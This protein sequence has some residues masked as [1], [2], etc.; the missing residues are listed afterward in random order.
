MDVESSLLSAPT[1]HAVSASEVMRGFGIDPKRGL[2]DDEVRR[3]ETLAGPNELEPPQR[4]TVWRMVLD[5]A[6]EPFVLLLLA[7][8]VGAI[9]VGEARDGWL[10]LAGL[11]R[12]SA[13]MS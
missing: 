1:A 12:S 10:V 5:A 4:P 6:T 9:L 7:A 3:R 13:R 8:G 2:T 11:I